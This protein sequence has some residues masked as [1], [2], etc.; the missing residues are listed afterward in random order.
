[1]LAVLYIFAFLLIAVLVGVLHFSSRGVSLDNLVNLSRVIGYTPP[2]GFYTYN[3]SVCFDEKRRRMYFSM[4]VSNKG[5]GDDPRVTINNLVM[6][7]TNFKF[8]ANEFNSGE[9]KYTE[10]DLTTVNLPTSVNNVGIEDVRLWC[11]N[12]ELY[13]IGTYV[14]K[15]RKNQ[16][17]I[18]QFDPDTLQMLNLKSV[19]S[20]KNEK[21][22]APII[23]ESYSNDDAQLF[24]Y[25]WDPF[26]IITT[27]TKV[28]TET[29][30]NMIERGV[31]GASNLKNCRGGSQVI[32]CHG[33]LNGYL[34]IV[35]T[36]DIAGKNY[37]HYLV[38]L[39]A[40]LNIVRVSDSFCIG[41][42][43]NT[44]PTLCRVEF[45]SG[46]VAFGDKLIVT[47]GANDCTAHVSF[48]DLKHV[49]K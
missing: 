17:V 15:S 1:M 35:H 48:V 28:K 2:P 20:S 10:L 36:R 11:R 32:R 39:D 46:M 42:I 43:S 29:I 41:T 30:A 23:N 8:G 3:P 19:S 31:V 16:M 12:R 14:N 26:V 4:R 25:S 21:N 6:A 40:K 49:W 5:C 7:Y 24:V 22:W 37:R 27:D 33:N 34:A 44:P 38:Q 47:Y 9:F 45:I 18:I 13:G